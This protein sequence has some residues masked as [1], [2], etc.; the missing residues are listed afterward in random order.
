[1]PSRALKRTIDLL[2]MRSGLRSGR[3]TPRLVS[4]PVER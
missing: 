3:L 4:L 2:A 1:M